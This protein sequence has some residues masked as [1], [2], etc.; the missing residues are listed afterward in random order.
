M[1]NV[2]P[3]GWEYKSLSDI[4]SVD[5]DN[6][7]NSTVSDYEFKYIDIASV[8]TGKISIPTER[9]AFEHSPSRARKKVRKGDVLMATVRPNLQA[10]AYFEEK[11]DD[12]IAS[13]GFAVVRSKA[14]NSGR[15]ILNS[16]LGDDVT[17]QIEAL[18]VGSN[19]PAINSSDVK[20]LEILTPH[21]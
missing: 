19:Y 5:G 6:L 21:Q 2:V 1:S 7:K 18:V 4:A 8:S 20:N 13:T 11:G 3:D 14:N 16:L 12:F 15:F 9:I 17:R 10:F